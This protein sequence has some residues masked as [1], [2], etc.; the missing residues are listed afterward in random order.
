MFILYSAE[1]HDVMIKIWLRM[2]VAYRG[3][4]NYKSCLETIDIVLNYSPDNKE[5]LNL[6]Q[7][8]E[9]ESKQVDETKQILKVINIEEKSSVSDKSLLDKNLNLSE[10][11][12]LL[13]KKSEFLPNLNYFLLSDCSC[14]INSLNAD[15]CPSLGNINTNLT[16]IYIL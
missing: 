7:E 4:S 6:K 5:A 1:T 15:S 9:L 12:Q 3:L 10:Q 8:V 14:S 13:S 2:S 16:G 11:T